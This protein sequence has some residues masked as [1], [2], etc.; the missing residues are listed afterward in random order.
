MAETFIINQ[1]MIKSRSM[2][3]L[4][5]IATGIGDDYTTGCLLNYQY[6]KDHYQLIV[7][8]LSN[9]P[10][11]FLSTT[12]QTTK[13]R[14]AIENNISTDIKL[15]KVQISKIVQSEGYLGFLLSKLVGALMKV[16]VP[17]GKKYFNTFRIN[18]CNVCN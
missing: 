9:L 16:A 11:E 15:S 5:K 14:N 12:R 17:L 4:E 6:F 7:V 10:H 18:Y 13:L 3:K 8:D 1:L 2:M